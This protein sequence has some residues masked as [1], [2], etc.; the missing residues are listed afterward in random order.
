[1]ITADHGDDPAFRGTD[2][3]RERVPIFLPNASGTIGARETYAD[4]AATLAAY[5]HL[6]PWPIGRS[7]LP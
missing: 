1:M 7:L 5:F 3:T 6:A 4:V 2:Y